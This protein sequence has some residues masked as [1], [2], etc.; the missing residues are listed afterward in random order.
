MSRARILADYVS[1]GTTAAEFDYLDGV[2]SNIQTQLTAKAPIA[3]PTFTGTVGGLGTP[4][5]NLGSATGAIPAGVTG[6]AGLTG[7]TSLGTVT[8]GDISHAD[9][10]YPAGHIVQVRDI[11]TG[12]DENTSSSSPEDF[13]EDTITF[14]AGNEI[15]TIANVGYFVVSGGADKGMAARLYDETNDA[16][17]FTR[18]MYLNIPSDTSNEFGGEQTLMNK[19]AFAGTSVQIKLQYRAT[20]G[21]TVYV[22]INSHLILMEIQA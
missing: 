9:I 14:T 10:V 22:G 15:L 19:T 20:S 2:T 12:V 6:G 5:I 1:G 8:A 4:V 7:S 16:E 11:V 13:M 21:G 3:G 18:T 17:L